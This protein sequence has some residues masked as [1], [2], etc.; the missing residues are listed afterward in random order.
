MKLSPFFLFSLGLHGTIAIT[1]LLRLD[2]WPVLLALF[3]LNHLVL[4]FGSVWPRSR[5]LGANIWEL[6]VESAARG[7]VAITIDDG[8]DPEVTPQVLAILAAHGAHASFFCIGERA[9][10]HPELVQAIAAAG[11]RIENHG[12]HHRT[13]QAFASYQGWQGEIAGAQDVLTQLAG[14]PPRFYRPIAGVR[15]PF[16]APALQAQGLQLVTWSRRGFDTCSKNPARVLQR[17]TKQ[18]KAGDILLLHDGN[19]ARDVAG[20]P[21]IL[22]VLP[23]LLAELEQRGLRGVALPEGICDE[24]L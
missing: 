17:L 4:A 21:V 9:S 2:W 14:T 1:L 20:L 3:V 24:F 11:H 7:E 10:A 18:L 6:P 5:L 13:R 22:T 8:P 23:A 16:L 15:N 19:A 12:M